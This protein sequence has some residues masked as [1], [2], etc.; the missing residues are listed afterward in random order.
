M[1]SDCWA[2]IQE[3]DFTAVGDRLK[4]AF[5]DAKN[6]VMD[7]DWKALGSDIIEMVADGAKAIIETVLKIGDWI[8]TTVNNWISAGGP[9]KLGES[10]ATTIG[11][12]IKSL[13]GGSS[14][15]FWDLVK[16]CFGTASDWLSMGWQIIKASV[17]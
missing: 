10:I 3:G 5:E 6:Y 4:Q 11:N 13:I 8:Y 15:S 2:A 9:E 7:I 12:G 14:F 17:S 1:A 16:K